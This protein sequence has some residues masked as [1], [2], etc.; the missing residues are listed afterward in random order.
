MTVSE[1]VK[2]PLEPGIPGRPSPAGGRQAQDGLPGAP[3]RCSGA[4]GAQLSPLG[5]QGPVPGPPDGGRVKDSVARSKEEWA[6]PLA[7]GRRAGQ[8]RPLS[9]KGR[10]AAEAPERA[11]WAAG[12]EVMK[13]DRVLRLP[14]FGK[15]QRGPRRGVGGRSLE[16]SN[17]T[18]GPQLS[19]LLKQGRH[20]SRNSKG[21][22]GV[23]GASWVLKLGLQSHAFCV[24]VEGG[25]TAAS[26]Q[27][28]GPDTRESFSLSAIS[29][30]QLVT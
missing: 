12:A 4:Q 6:V 18:A 16:C 7:L 27:R 14:L 2:I 19:Q 1:S 15:P 26:E 9:P 5:A 17:L 28:R 8:G 11:A 13:R 20:K 10:H 30:F 21:W 23:N 29:N 3:E 25:Q 24:S 22:W